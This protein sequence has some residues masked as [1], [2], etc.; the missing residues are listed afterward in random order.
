MA[1]VAASQRLATVCARYPHGH[2]V[3]AAL[4]FVPDRSVVVVVVVGRINWPRAETREDVQRPSVCMY[5]RAYVRYI[6]TI[7][8]VIMYTTKIIR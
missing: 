6:I 5:L 4:K 1:I 8:I 2:R 3:F 7:I